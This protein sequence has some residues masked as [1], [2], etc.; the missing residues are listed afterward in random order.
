M[1]ATINYGTGWLAAFVAAV[2]VACGPMRAPTS[3]AGISP[4]G[5]P[6]APTP[7]QPAPSPLRAAPVPFEPPP[8]GSKEPQPQ[9]G[10]KADTPPTPGAGTARPTTDAPVLSP[11]MPDSERLR[12]EVNKRL[13]QADR[14]IEAIDPGKLARDQREIYVSLVNFVAKARSALSAEDLAGA[15]VLSEKASKLAE[16]LASTH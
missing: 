15:D 2:A 10:P 6:A 14:V 7:V 12:Q 1:S 4:E 5:G 3:G 13:G 16:A 9:S 11:H 8:K